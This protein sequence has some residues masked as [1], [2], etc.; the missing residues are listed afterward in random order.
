MSDYRALTDVRDREWV[1]RAPSSCCQ[2]VVMLHRVPKSSP[3]QSRVA[4][5][6]KGKVETRRCTHHGVLCQS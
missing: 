1:V 6:A 5:H 3:A 4:S 2:M